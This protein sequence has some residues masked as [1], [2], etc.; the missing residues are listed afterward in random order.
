M[1]VIKQTLLVLILLLSYSSLMAKE[2]ILNN[3]Y[4]LPYYVVK[5]LRQIAREAGEFNVTVSSKQRS[6]KKQVE[7]MLD[8]YITCG[9]VSNPEQKDNCG[10]ELAKNVYDQECHAAFEVYDENSSRD[11]NVE[12]MTDVLT[13]SL[14]LLGKDR[15]CMNH[16]TIPQIYT[17]IIAVDLKPS[18]VTDLA[19]FYDAVKRNTSVVQFYYPNINGRPKSAVKDAAFHIGFLRQ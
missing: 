11:A 19:K 15:R 18:S 8:Y 6:V 4:G 7:V 17:P 9:K 13:D 10:I 12:I 3:A 16:V 2:P 5:E 14:I 1:N